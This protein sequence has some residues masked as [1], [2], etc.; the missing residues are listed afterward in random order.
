LVGNVTG[1]ATTA[2]TA[3]SATTATTANNFSGSL[4]GNVTGTQSATVVSTV[5]GV[6]AINVANGA[7]AANAATSADTASTIVARDGSGNFSAGT[8]TA[9]LAGNAATATTATTATTF[10]GSVS[11]SQLSANIARLN[12]TN[13]FTG[14]NNFAGV[15]IVTNVNNVIAGAISGTGA[16]LTGLNASHLTTGTVPVAQLP[17]ATTTTLGVVQPDGTS[18]NVNSG[19]ISVSPGGGVTTTYIT[20][21]MI[22][23]TALNITYPHGLGTFPGFVHPILLCTTTDRDAGMVA[24]QMTEFS[25]VCFNNNFDVPIG[26]FASVSYDTTNIYIQTTAEGSF[27]YY[28]FPTGGSPASWNDFAIVVGFHQ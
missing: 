17:V 9:N 12:G 27:Y 6:T 25:S 18:I 21:N 5:G 15:S 7:N 11:D 4:T 20:N 16:G 24:G 8:I 22:D 3:T 10:S 28:M 19:V 13:D 14:T 1:N 26:V 2:T 23:G